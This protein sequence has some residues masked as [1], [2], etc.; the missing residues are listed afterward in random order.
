MSDFN[1]FSSKTDIKKLLFTTE[2]FKFNE[3]CSNDS[4]Q[5]LPGVTS[6]SAIASWLDNQNIQK[7]TSPSLSDDGNQFVWAT[8][9][10]NSAVRKSSASNFEHKPKKRTND[11]RRGHRLP[12]P[13]HTNTKQSIFHDDKKPLPTTTNQLRNEP[14]FPD[15]CE[16]I[17]ISVDFDVPTDQ[18]VVDQ[19][20]V[21][22][23]NVHL[24]K[25]KVQQHQNMTSSR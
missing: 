9:E 8:V 18:L 5:D 2:K 7:S 19:D 1:L 23:E 15:S 17:T 16:S 20:H 13:S 4:W 10:H 3:Q 12:L 6:T 25:N 24:W 11:C 22:R 21:T 14:T